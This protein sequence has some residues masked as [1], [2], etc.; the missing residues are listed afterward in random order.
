[1]QDADAGCGCKMPDAG[2]RMQDA[3]QMPQMPDADANNEEYII[4]EEGRVCF[5]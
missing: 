5:C 2:C 3:M 1:M 4:N